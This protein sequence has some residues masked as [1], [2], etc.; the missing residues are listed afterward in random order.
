MNV[1]DFILLMAN[2]AAQTQPNYVNP[3]ELAEIYNRK[4]GNTNEQTMFQ[5]CENLVQEGSLKRQNIN[6]DNNQ[7]NNNLYFQ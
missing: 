4:H 3:V 5:E 7:L 1:R 6:P 2:S